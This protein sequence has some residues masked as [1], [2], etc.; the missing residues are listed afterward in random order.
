AL[1]LSPEGAGLQ[2]A[3]LQSLEEFAGA[4]LRV[5]YTQP[6]GYRWQPS[7]LQLGYPM[8][9]P[10]EPGPRGRL[11][12]LPPVQGRTPE[13]ALQ[14]AHR[15]DPRL[16]EGLCRLD[17]E[18]QGDPSL[19]VSPVVPRAAEI[20]PTSLDLWLLYFLGPTSTRPNL[21]RGLNHNFSQTHQGWE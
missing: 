13:E 16:R 17:P 8:V 6:G 9:V 2:G 10:L 19:P 12:L 20:A 14:A 5:E 3:P 15:L 4:S 7:R 21:T 11:T 18:H 1:A